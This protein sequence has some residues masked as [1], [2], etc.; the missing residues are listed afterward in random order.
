MRGPSSTSWT[1]LPDAASDQPV[2]ILARTQ[3]G[4]GL[5]LTEDAPQAWH[6]GAMTEQQRTDARAEIEAR[7][8]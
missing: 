3:K 8:R 5:A 7:M 1:G 4:R 2:C 6:L